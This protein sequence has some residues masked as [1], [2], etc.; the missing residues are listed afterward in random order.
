MDAAA[1]AGDITKTGH[2][3][4][5]GIYFDTA[6][7][8]VKPESDAALQEIAKLLQQNAQLK[9]LVVGHTDTVL[10]PSRPAWTFP[11]GAPTRWFRC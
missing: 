7:A 4:V 11:N 8:E 3:A 1:L 9:L 2:S 6:K 10:A 5:Y